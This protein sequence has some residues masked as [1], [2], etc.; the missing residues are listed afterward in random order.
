MRNTTVDIVV[1]ALAKSVQ[2]IAK[3]LSA[4]FKAHAIIPPVVND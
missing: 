2:N 1:D 3:K 4:M